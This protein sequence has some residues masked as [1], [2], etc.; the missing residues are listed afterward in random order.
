M[1]IARRRTANGREPKTVVELSSY[2]GQFL[3]SRGMSLR[4]IGAS[5]PRTLQFAEHDGLLVTLCFRLSQP[6]NRLVLEVGTQDDPAIID[7][8][9]RDHQPVVTGLPLPRAHHVL[10]QL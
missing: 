2:I 10:L 5:V 3:K 6:V 8:V 4:Q 1:G 7:T 9:E